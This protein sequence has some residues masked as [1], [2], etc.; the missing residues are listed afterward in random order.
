[1]Q[2][3]GQTVSTVT[4]LRLGEVQGVGVDR[5]FWDGDGAGLADVGGIHIQGFGHVFLL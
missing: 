3:R 5:D 1:M 4:L 2:H